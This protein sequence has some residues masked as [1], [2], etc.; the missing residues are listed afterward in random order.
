[1]YLL[2]IR[3]FPKE[4]PRVTRSGTFMSDRYTSARDTL[5]FHLRALHLPCIPAPEPVALILH[6][7]YSNQRTADLDNLAGG[8]MDAANSILYT[9]DK[10]VVSLTCTKQVTGTDSISFTVAPLPSH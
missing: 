9:D 10:Q 3:P 4:R 2:D 7:T 1:M 8:F 6:F 5:S